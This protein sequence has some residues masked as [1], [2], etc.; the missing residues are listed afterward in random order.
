MKPIGLRRMAGLGP[1]SL[2][3]ED[4]NSTPPRTEFAAPTLHRYTDMADFMLV[5]PIHEV[6]ENRA[7][8][9][10]KPAL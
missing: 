8:R 2:M 5:D 10:R 7:G 9:N 1:G 3:P 4:S 6:A